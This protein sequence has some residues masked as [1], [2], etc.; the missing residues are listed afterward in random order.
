MVDSTSRRVGARS[1]FVLVGLVVEGVQGP[2]EAIGSVYHG[3]CVDLQEAGLEGL[4]GHL[5]HIFGGDVCAH[6][7]GQ[8]VRAEETHG[9]ASPVCLG[10]LVVT[11]DKLPG[12]QNVLL[13][14]LCG[15][16]VDEV[17][18]FRAARGNVHAGDIASKLR[19]SSSCGRGSS[20]NF[21]ACV[22]HF[23]KD[24]IDW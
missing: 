2:E 20:L 19:S 14:Q 22:C 18:R 23:A 16:G 17:S 12:E 15:A 10:N 24:R 6:E 5:V 7:E 4:P 13:R 9:P 21:S 3:A 1:N 11:E 8:D